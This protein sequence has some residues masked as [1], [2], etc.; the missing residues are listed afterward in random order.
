MIAGFDGWMR[1]TEGVSCCCGGRWRWMRA[2]A[3]RRWAWI[4][5]AVLWHVH[6]QRTRTR[7][8]TSAVFAS[9]L[10]RARGNIRKERRKD[11]RGTRQVFM[12]W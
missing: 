2:R 10:A 6:E 7:F 5:R 4:A 11:M 9:C 12:R 1:C 3:A 8:P